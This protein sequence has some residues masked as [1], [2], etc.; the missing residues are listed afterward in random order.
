LIDYSEKNRIDGESEIDRLIS[1]KYSSWRMAALHAK[2]VIIA[3]DSG[4]VNGLMNLDGILELLPEG[5]K[6][7]LAQT[8][9]VREKVSSVCRQQLYANSVDRPFFREQAIMGLRA[10]INAFIA[11]VSGFHE[12]L[13]SEFRRAAEAWLRI[14]DVQL[15]AVQKARRREPTPQIF[16]AG[17]P[18]QRD[19][20]A[21]V[22]RST[23]IATLE[24][25]IM[26]SVG[27]PGLL[28]YGRRRVGKS[29]VINNLDGFLPTSITQIVISMQRPEACSSESSES[30]LAGLLGREIRARNRAASRIGPEPTD[31]ITL[32]EFFGSCNR[33]L[34][35]DNHRLLV[36]IDEFEELDRGVGE[37]R[38]T[39]GLPKTLRESVQNHRSITWLFAGSHHFSELPNVRWSSYLVSLRTLELPP[40]TKAETQLLLTDP[41]RHSRRAEAKEGVRMFGASFWGEGVVDRIHEYTAGW[42]HLVQLVASTIVDLSNTQG[43]NRCD[44]E[45]LKEGLTK[46]LESGDTVLAELML[47]RSEEYPGAWAYLSGFRTQQQQPPPAG[48]ELRIALKRSLLIKETQDRQWTLRV[49]MLGRWLR[50]RT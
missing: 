8:H 44:S 39:E 5:E 2:T 27:C 19:A 6:G 12:P 10:E 1:K 28:L 13:A 41:L 45:L 40:F 15:A 34:E 7:F 29:T 31:L 3:R 37:K 49:P 4:G 30:T 50:E 23:I 48:D 25:E 46:S 38:F 26:A 43:K 33:Q 17:A 35:T 20:E 24:N 18:V 21:F 9:V 11:Q 16:R 22:E 47:Y 14:A 36:C 32:Y 42:P